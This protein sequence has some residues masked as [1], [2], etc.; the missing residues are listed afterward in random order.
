MRLVPWP[1]PPAR[2]APAAP[3][4]ATPNG[5]SEGYVVVVQELVVDAGGPRSSNLGPSESRRVH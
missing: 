4:T 5:P 3:A 1:V 2:G